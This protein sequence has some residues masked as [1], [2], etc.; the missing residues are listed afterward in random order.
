MCVTGSC[1]IGD[2]LAQLGSIWKGQERLHELCGEHGAGV[3]MA[4]VDEII[5]YA[6]RRAAEAIRAMPDGVYEAEGWIDSDGFDQ[7]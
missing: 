1:C 3:V 6:D 5:D 4:Y 2:L 7:D